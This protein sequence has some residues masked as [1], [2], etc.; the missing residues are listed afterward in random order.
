M[1]PTRPRAPRRRRPGPTQPLSRDRVLRAALAV[2]DR[3]GLDAVSMRRVG[4]ELGVAGMSLYHHV[5][6]KAALLDGVFEAILAEMAPPRRTRHW[7]AA[8]TDRALAL[9]DV[10]RAHPHALPLFA[11][12]PAVTPASLVHVERVLAVLRAAGFGPRAALTAFQ[13]VL[14][15]VVGHTLGAHGPSAGGAPPR[16]AYADLDPRAFPRVREAAPLLATIDPD[17]ELAAGL[18]ALLAGLSPRD[19]T[20]AGSAPA[21]PRPGRGRSRRARRRGR[22]R[23]GAAT[24]RR[25]PRTGCR[26]RRST[27]RR[28]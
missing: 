1:P 21:R 26:P 25:D 27:R 14:A 13:V 3:D 18:R 8:L 6:D 23:T 22:A 20:A 12:R 19:A 9:R 17:R 4:A 11:T 28:R 16:P 15:L 24:R 10:L 7:R 2:L 5:A